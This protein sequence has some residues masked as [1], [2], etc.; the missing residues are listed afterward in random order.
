MENHLSQEEVGTQA[1]HCTQTEGDVVAHY[2]IVTIIEKGVKLGEILASNGIRGTKRV[3]VSKSSN[4]NKESSLKETYRDLAMV[5]V[6][7]TLKDGRKCKKRK[8]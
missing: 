5:L 2:K 4:S 8:A 3:H 6:G 7:P 1:Q